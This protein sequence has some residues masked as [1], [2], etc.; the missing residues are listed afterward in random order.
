VADGL[1]AYLDGVQVY[2]EAGPYTG[3]AKKEIRLAQT[4]VLKGEKAEQAVRTVICREVVPG[5]KEGSLAS[6]V[7]D[8]GG[9]AC[10]RADGFPAAAAPR[11]GLPSGGL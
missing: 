1:T 7:H 6:V 3:A 5:A 11:T 2:S 4:T 9:G 10:G 8:Q